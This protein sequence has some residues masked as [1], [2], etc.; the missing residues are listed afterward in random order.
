LI[1]LKDIRLD[2]GGAPVLDGVDVSVEEGDRVCLLGI[3]GA[4]K[5][6]LIKVMAGI[7]APDGG[8]VLWR[9]GARITFLP[10]DVPQDIHGKV[11]DVV[12]GDGGGSSG[13]DK[14]QAAREILARQDL[15][16]TAEFG[17]L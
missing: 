9:S 15:D 2:F 4:G 17:A 8:K 13:E 10:Q 11:L 5:S 14:L 12:L 1:S 7:V 3:N 16:E 6:S